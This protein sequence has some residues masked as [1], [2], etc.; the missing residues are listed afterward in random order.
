MMLRRLLQPLLALVALSFAAAP[1]LAGGIALGDAAPTADVKMKNVDGREVTIASVKGEKGTLVVF[2]CN[3]CPWA[4]AWETRVAD[5]ANTYSKKGV[6]VVVINSNDP[7]V[8]PEDGAAEMVARARKLKL[9]VPY[10][11]DATSD[12]ARAFGATRTPEAYLFDRS[13]KLVYH[14]TIDDN[15]REPEKVQ[16]RYLRDA[17]EATLAGKAVPV[18]ETKALGCSI[19]F[20]GAKAS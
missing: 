5:L 4:K 7:S 8:V 6:G 1:A 17:L 16:A 11:V 3:A 19:K 9:A 14:G 13:G 2:S 15:A 20:R 10:V 18:A 12:V